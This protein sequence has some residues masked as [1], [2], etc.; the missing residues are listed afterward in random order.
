MSIY[1][2][3][4]ENPDK[5]KS[6]EKQPLHARVVPSGTY[7][8]EEFIDYVSKAQHVP[9]AQ[10][11]ASIEAIVSELKT[12]LAR[13]YI[14]EF[15]ELG[16]L[17][18]TLKTNRK[19]MNRKEVRSPSISLKDIT[20]KVNKQYKKELGAMMELERISSSTRSRQQLTDEECLARLQQF[21]ETHPCINRADYSA[22]T[23]TN[24]MKAIRQLQT[25]IEQG[26][27]RKYGTGKAVVYIP[28]RR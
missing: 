15:G 26:I 18:V 2:D 20:L 1:Y 13:G 24:K 25:F 11:T 16:H 6:G 27:I 10:L 12:L 23:G 17:S 5:E 4:Y 3:L 14:V 7:S 9:H 28:Q 19:I 8:A 22:L 21:F